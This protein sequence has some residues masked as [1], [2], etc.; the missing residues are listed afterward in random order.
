[1]NNSINN[2]KQVKTTSVT[3]IVLLN[4]NGWQDT[5]ACIKSL[6]AMKED[7]FCIFIADNHSSDDSIEE[8]QQWLKQN[9]KTY[10]FLLEGETVNTLSPLSTYI[11]SFSSNH[12]F[13]KANNLI[14]K[15]IANVPYENALI[16]NND[17]EVEPDFLRRLL[18]FKIKNPTYKIL[19]PLICYFEPKDKIWN[20]GGRLFF[21]MRKY[22]YNNKHIKAIKKIEK[23]EIS[24]VTGCAL[25]FEKT[26]L[27]QD[28]LFTE[29]FFFGEEDFELSMR[30][31]KTNQKI[32]CVL[33]SKIYHKVS[34]STANI[35][36]SNKIYLYYLNRFINI[37]HHYNAVSY[38][39][40]KHLYL[41]YI[42]Y[43]LRK[44][45]IPIKEI[46]RFIKK[47]YK[48]SRQYNEVNKAMFQDIMQIK[49][50]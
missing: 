48:E 7:N 26:I 10:Q 30:M 35:E 21:G 41:G 14:L 12:G 46:C 43:L 44:H 15:T 34:S 33:N 20:A 4:W 37:K 9:K 50:F 32:A 28:R 49:T 6:Y 5:I 47:L 16:L 18:D 31:K 29:K 11:F 19:T 38:F 8:I 25:F 36:K 45:S 39:F 1:M 2:N 22:C 23:I 27:S 13:A 17:T 40:W 3:P 42:F 24:F